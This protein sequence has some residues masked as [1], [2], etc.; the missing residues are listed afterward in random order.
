MFELLHALL[1]RHIGHDWERSVTGEFV[2]VSESKRLIVYK[3][4]FDGSYRY[5]IQDNRFDFCDS[6]YS[7][8]GFASETAAKEACEQAFFGPHVYSYA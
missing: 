2:R 5:C 7:E 4:R 6:E 3:D 1:G 8:R